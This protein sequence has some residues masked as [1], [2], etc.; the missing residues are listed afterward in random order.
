MA[1]PAERL[2]ADRLRYPALIGKEVILMR[3]WERRHLTDYD[4]M[5]FNVYLGSGRDPGPSYPAYIR[6][7]AVQISQKRVDGVAWLRG[8]PTIIEVKDRVTASAIGQI[9]TYQALWPFNYPESPAPTLLF[10]CREVEPDM[11]QVLQHH[12][13]Q[14]ETDATVDY[15]E[16]FA[17]PKPADTSA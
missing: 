17:E 16:L 14:W 7:M 15:S 5:D 12:G 3:Q 4:T 1:N 9:L 2:R 13:I 10:V 6:K 11:V 8:V